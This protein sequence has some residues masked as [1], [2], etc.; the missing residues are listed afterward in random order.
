MTKSDNGGKT[1]TMKASDLLNVLSHLPG[2]TVV[3]DISLNTSEGTK[4]ASDVLARLQGRAAESYD[5]GT[6]GGT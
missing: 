2:D 3:A 4:Y 5:D 6:D 1:R